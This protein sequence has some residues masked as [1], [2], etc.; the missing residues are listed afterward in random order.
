MI[1]CKITN[2]TEMK[3]THSSVI[4]KKAAKTVLKYWKK[5]VILHLYYREKV[6]KKALKHRNI[7][8]GTEIVIIFAA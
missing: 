3:T 7:A 2:K 4:W 1:F 8:A 5:V 6:T